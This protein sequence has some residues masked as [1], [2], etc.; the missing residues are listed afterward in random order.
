MGLDVVTV[1]L[2]VR[3][4]VDLQYNVLLEEMILSSFLN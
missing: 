3:L 4:V 2:Y 1:L